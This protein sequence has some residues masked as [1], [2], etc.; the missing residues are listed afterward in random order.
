MVSLATGAPFVSEKQHIPGGTPYFAL[1]GS[2]S[3]HCVDCQISRR[4]GESV[5]GDKRDGEGGEVVGQGKPD[6]PQ[7][8][9]EDETIGSAP[10][11]QA[12]VRYS[13]RVCSALW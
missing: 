5:C 8:K 2:L 4:E 7:Y 9:R 1:L 3:R 13:A 11:E 6:K 12:W 10:Y